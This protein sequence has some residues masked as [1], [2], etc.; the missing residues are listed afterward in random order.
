MHGGTFI[1]NVMLQY[2][3]RAT[4]IGEDQSMEQI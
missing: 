1:K 2:Q 3:A 4:G